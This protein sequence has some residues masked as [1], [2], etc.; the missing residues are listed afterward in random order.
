MTI[1]SRAS[2]GILATALLGACTAAS[3]N[4][5]HRYSFSGNANDSVGNVHGILKNA[6]RISGGKL[7]LENNGQPS[8]ETSAYLE[9]PAPIIPKA[10]SASIVF[11]YDS[12][13][14][15]SFARIIDF[16][17]RDNGEGRAF[18]YFTASA[19]DG[20][21]RAAMSATDVAGR[22]FVDAPTI[23]DGKPHA[24]AMVID[25]TTKRLRLFIDG[26]EAGESA[27]LGDATLDAIH[28]THSWIGRSGFDVDSGLTGNLDELRIYDKAL[29]A[30]EIAGIAAA[31]P[32][33]LPAAKH[34]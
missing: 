6:A 22:I 7:V 3:L 1:F 33:K 17:D 4:L 31:G 11:W 28:P 20:S 19:G 25:G 16:G 12:K 9:F 26:K 5:T 18:I 24:V 34:D 23:A 10:G 14:T 15:D 27:E 32:D 30:E 29:S 13:S 8:S 21:T 2:I